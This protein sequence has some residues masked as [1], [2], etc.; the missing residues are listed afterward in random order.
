MNDIVNAIDGSWASQAVLA[1]TWFWPTLQMFHFVG[2]CLLFG[3]VLL[4]DLRLLGM[5][6]F[7]AYEWVHRLIPLAMVGFVINLITGVLFFVGDPNTYYPNLAF[8]L[9]MLFIV[10]AG[11]NLLV[12]WFWLKDTM[13]RVGPGEAT[14]LLA[15]GVG[16]ASITLWLGVIAGGRMI[17][18]VF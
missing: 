1:T 7:F 10:L 15:K 2:L 6:R 9:K 14:P 13:F 17:P 5:L 4:V 8:R 16:A 11:A 18:W 12:F 3:I